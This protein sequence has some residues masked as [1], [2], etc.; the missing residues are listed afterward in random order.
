L[1]LLPNPA[2]AQV[3]ASCEEFTKTHPGFAELIGGSVEYEDIYGS[4]FKVS[5]C[6]DSFAECG[7]CNGGGNAG[8][9]EIWLGKKKRSESVDSADLNL[10]KR[11]TVEKEGNCIG[12]FAAATAITVGSGMTGLDCAS[13]I[14]YCFT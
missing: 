1:V 10:T 8:Y 11:E 12:K 5:I 14:S 13:S 4:L 9:C 2:L 3:P 6:T 7:E